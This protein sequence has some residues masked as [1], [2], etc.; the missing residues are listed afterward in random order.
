LRLEGDEVG[1][2][3]ALTEAIN[4]NSLAGIKA[5]VE[6]GLDPTLSIEHRGYNVL[7]KAVWTSTAEEA[8]VVSYL[9]GLGVFDLEQPDYDGNTPFVRA[10]Q[11][12]RLA[13]A[14]VLHAAGCRLGVLPEAGSNSLAWTFADWIAG[15]PH[16]AA[17]LQWE[18]GI[19]LPAL[20]SVSKHSTVLLYVADAGSVD[21]VQALFAVG[22]E[23]GLEDLKKQLNL[24]APGATRRWR[25]RCWTESGRA[26]TRLGRMPRKGVA[27]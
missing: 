5:L 22:F 4:R 19:D 3:L 23:P 11:N 25:P 17:V 21:G 8:G 15:D 14:R 7:S 1:G 9:V 2:E 16:I 18:L 26:L 13:A 20:G 12:R 6:G 27:R 24:L 10:L